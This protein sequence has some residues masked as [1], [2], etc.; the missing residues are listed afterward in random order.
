[1]K[2][3]V[4]SHACVTAVNQ[5]FFADAA[6]LSGWDIDI[7]VPERWNT[8]YAA[9]VEPERWPT[10]AGNLYRIPVWK[11]GNIPLHVYKR[12]M[13]GLLRTVKPDLIYVHHEPYGAAT[14]QVYLANALSC[15]APIGF[16]A[17]QNIV[18]N[19]PV[20]FR[21]FEQM[22]FR[23]SSFCF[24]VT[25]GADEVLRKKGYRG[26]SQVLPL[27]VD[28]A[29]YRP[30]REW[31]ERKKAELGFA[32][33]EFIFGYIGRLTEEK[34]L[35]SLLEAASRIQEP[36]WR[37]V[38]VGSGPMEAALRGE[39]ERL[40][41]TAKVLFAG[42]VPHSAVAGWLTMMDVLLLPSE[43]R[44]NWKE[45]FGRVIV[46]ANA[47]ETAVIGTDS[48]EIASVL[49]ATGG[50][51]VV[52]EK[53]AG[54]LHQAMQRLMTHRAET[55]ALAL[56]GAESAR[57]FFDQEY[58]AEQFVTTLREATASGGPQ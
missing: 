12:T 7:A 1:M 13:I 30:Q 21:W 22:V 58:L 11:S 44:P 19:Y 43:T 18:K 3:L 20:P 46:E 33:Q 2:L 49:R 47:C 39:V 41:L 31:A 28:A 48:G 50:G 56:Q 5:A 36:G 54:A 45:Q 6:R 10:F 15:R 27:A 51:V 16:Y 35:A 17:A 8:E 26:R 53:D 37:C 25:M 38:L 24:P 52:P 23:A 32:P 42:Y 4:V 14:A 29:V 40:G 9:S 34:G 55:E 57:R